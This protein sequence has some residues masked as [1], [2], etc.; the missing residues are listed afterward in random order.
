MG[1]VGTR[2]HSGGGTTPVSRY[3]LVLTTTTTVL[4]STGTSSTCSSVYYCQHSI[5]YTITIINNTM[6]TLA[7]ATSRSSSLKMI[8][9][10]S[11]TS[12]NHTIRVAGPAA[13][14]SSS[15]IAAASDTHY[16]QSR[17]PT[18]VRLIFTNM[19]QYTN[20]AIYVCITFTF[21]LD[22]V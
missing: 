13:S 14:F 11:S 8:M 4:A 22:Y 18:P 19:I 17:K 15:P 2:Y 12:R 7:F 21:Y 5:T 9:A 10:R 6:T 16:N 1:L 20:L 3:L